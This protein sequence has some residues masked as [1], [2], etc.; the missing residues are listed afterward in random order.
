MTRKVVIVAPNYV[1]DFFAGCDDWDTQIPC[2]SIEDMWDGLSDG[3]LS[4]E[5][6]IIIISDTLFS[7]TPEDFLEAVA[8]FAPNSLVMVLSFGIVHELIRAQVKEFAQKNQFPEA[9]FHFIRPEVCLSE[10]KEAIYQYD[11]ADRSIVYYAEDPSESVF[12]DADSVQE[13]D[14]S[15]DDLAIMFTPSKG[16]SGKL[17]Y[18]PTGG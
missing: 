8:T 6:E 17:F 16:G 15:D 14:L 13:T 2:E 11:H 5:S 18:Q 7:E 12:V 10:I 3:E 9:P 4:D 1:S